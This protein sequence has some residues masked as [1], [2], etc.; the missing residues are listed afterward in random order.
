MGKERGGDGVVAVSEDVGLDVNLIADGALG[1]KAATVDLR[2]DALNDDALASI[3][4]SQCH[5]ESLSGLLPLLDELLVEADGLLSDGG[6]AEDIF[7]AAAAGFTKLPA[8][9]RIFEEA[10]ERRGQVARKLYRIGRE[11][12]HRILLEGHQVAGF[13]IDDHLFDASGGAGDH[14]RAAGHGFE[15]DD[16]EGLIHRRA[17]EDAAVA[18]ELDGLRLGDHLLDPHDAGM[19]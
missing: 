16:A 11:A 9:L 18:V 5:D 17:A 19:V 13:S 7:D 2:S 14:R 4:C 8:L 15:I 6:P 1:G 10:S 3:F 12:G